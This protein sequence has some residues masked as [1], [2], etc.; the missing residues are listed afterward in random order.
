MAL[1][2]EKRDAAMK[3]WQE[4]IGSDRDLFRGVFLDSQSAVTNAESTVNELLRAAAG[5][6]NNGTDEWVRAEH[7]DNYPCLLY[8]S[9]AADE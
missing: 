2:E 6:G 7:M 9:D 3:A 4:T 1:L 5:N 8:T